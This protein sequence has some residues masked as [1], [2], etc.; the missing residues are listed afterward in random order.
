ME[1]LTIYFCKNNNL[2]MRESNYLT[3]VGE[4]STYTTATREKKWTSRE[5][6]TDLAEIRT[7]EPISTASATTCVIRRRKSSPNNFNNNERANLLD[8]WKRHGNFFF[9]SAQQNYLFK[10]IAR[11]CTDE[12]EIR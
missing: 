2:S 7:S 6:K 4:E 9:L 5:S 1:I 12:I 8:C 10:F 3:Q 11:I